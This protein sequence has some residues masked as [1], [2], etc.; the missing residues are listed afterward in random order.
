MLPKSQHQAY[1]G[2]NKGAKAIRYY[3][4]ATRNILTLRNYHFLEPL[5]P[6]PP[7]DIVVDMHDDQGEHAPLDEGENDRDQST[8]KSNTTIPKKR[9]AE[10]E[11]DI[12]EP[13]KAQG[14]QVSKD[15]DTREPCKT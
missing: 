10:N 13:R 2:I 3:N 1:V 11:I 14:V 12:R 8:Q 6:S 5:E 15:I 7:E 9:P 4:A